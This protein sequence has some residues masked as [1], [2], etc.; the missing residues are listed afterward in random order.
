MVLT[1]SNCGYP[2]WA[3]FRDLVKSILLRGCHEFAMFRS[4]SWKLVQN[5][6]KILHNL[7]MLL[8]CSCHALAIARSWRE[9]GKK[10]KDLD[11][12]LTWQ[13]RDNNTAKTWQEHEKDM[14][15]TWQEGDKNMTRT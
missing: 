12:N 1:V 4:R 6:S 3:S 14:I 11:K 9:H 15:C 5:L 2:D 8:P 13:Q 10:R 7:A